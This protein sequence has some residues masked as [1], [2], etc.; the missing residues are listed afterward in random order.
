M[1]DVVNTASRLQT[2][3]DPGTVL[4]G[5]DTYAA[6]RDVVS[7]RGH[8]P[9][10]SPRARSCRSRPG[11]PSAAIVPPGHRPRRTGAPLIG[12][13]TELALL[14]SVTS[15]AIDRCRAALLRR[16]RRG[17]HGQ[18][19]AGDRDE[20]LRDAATFDALVLEGRCVPYGEANV[21]W[22][23]ADAIRTAASI[24]TDATMDEIDAGL[25]GRSHGRPPANRGRLDE[26]DRVVAGLHHLLGH[27]GALR[28]IDAARARD[29]AI[30]SVV[31]I[32][33]GYT[34]RQP[35]MV[36]LS[37]LHWADQEVLDLVDTLLV[38]L[39]RRPFVL[40]ATARR[41]LRERWH[42]TPEA[43]NS[44]RPPPRPARRR[45]QP[46]AAVQ[47]HRGRAPPVAGVDAR[48][49]G[50]RQ[51]LLPRGAGGARHRGRGVHRRGPAGHRGR[52]AARARCGASSPPASTRSRPPTGTS[53]TMPRCSAAA[54]RSVLWSRWPTS[55]GASTP[56]RLAAHVENLAAR[57]FLVTRR[58][59]V[60]LPLRRHPRGRVL[61]A[62]QGRPGPVPRRHRGVD[63]AQR[64]RA[65][66]STSSTRSP[67]TTPR[68]P[69]SP[70]TSAT[71]A[72]CPTTCVER[73]V[74]LADTGGAAGRR[75]LLAGRR[76][77]AHRPGRSICSIDGDDRRHRAAPPPGRGPRRRSTT[78]TPPKPTPPCRS[79]W[80][81]RS[82]TSVGV[83]RAQL[84]LGEIHQHRGE[85]RLVDR[86]AR[87][88]PGAVRPS[89][90][91]IEAAADALR[92]QTG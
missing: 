43:A 58:R 55:S 42:P 53:S 46:H 14:T 16:P 19:A 21:W 34:H 57:E 86:R 39:A 32:A 37:D 45:R 79:S 72:A 27:D 74:D 62:H 49:P 30:R 85:F 70:P 66:R 52:R 5:P 13:E 2:A 33:E 29:E 65:T 41:S 17:G 51:P 40:M 83:A 22:P 23:V 82:A 81:P 67:T 54:T 47:P 50:R 68:R 12:R 88:R 90:A 20:Q 8:R 25:A 84:V 61:D 44:R 31:A 76:G 91:T 71:S 38:R 18:V 4:V 9:G 36:V 80:P 59:H 73:A 11:W 64:A 15:T 6:T 24:P 48:R 26:L 78:S 56:R 89:S 77:R 87:R 35:V 92:L 1:G 3:A 28:G 10:R 7:Y 75:R 63:R 60:L 69:S